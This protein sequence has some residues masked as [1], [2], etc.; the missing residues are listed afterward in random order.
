MPALI[1]LSGQ[2]FGQLTVVGR[3]QTS[4]SGKV[5]WSCS[6]ACGGETVST[7]S[8]LRGGLARSCGCSRAE[9]MPALAATNTTHGM[10]RTPTYRSWQA[11]I[12]RCEYP[13]SPSYER[14]GAVGV[15]V[16][17]EWRAS[18]SRF[19]AD[20]GE[21]PEGKTLDR[22]KNERGYEPGN[23]RWATNHEQALNRRPKG[24][25][26]LDRSTLDQDLFEDA[27]S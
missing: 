11:M 3:A 18:F 27:R 7:T 19:L 13:C 8:N 14:Y 23:C 6:C 4:G 10:T 15:K 25:R 5:R 9:H 20:M 12:A 16:C 26:A 1:D 2:T 17:P 22:I 24:F 21:R